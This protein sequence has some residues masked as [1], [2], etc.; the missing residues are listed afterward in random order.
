LER[1]VHGVGESVKRVVQICCGYPDVLDA[2]DYPKTGLG[3][4]LELSGSLDE[5]AFDA[6]S[7]EDAHGH[8][9]H[10]CS[11]GSRARP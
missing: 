1:C 3:A 9:D 6:L 10:G 2:T 7:L 5:A 11:I 8:N 4:Y